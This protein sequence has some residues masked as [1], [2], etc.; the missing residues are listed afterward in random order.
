MKVGIAGYSGSGVTT[1]MALLAEVPAL[2][3][4]RGGGPEVRSVKIPDARLDGL[5]RIFHP[6]KTTPVQMEM[7]EIGDLR[8]EEGG[9]LRK[10]ALGRTRGLDA[11]VLVLKGFAT[12]LD[13]PCRPEAEVAAELSDIFGEFCLSDLLPVENRLQRLKKEGKLSSGEA[14]L[15]ERVRMSLEEGKPLRV[16]GL[17][18]EEKRVLQGY[19]FLTLFPTLTVANVGEAGAGNQ[20]F[21]GLAG[22]CRGEGIG[23]LEVAGKTEL[24]LLDL[25]EEER[26]PFLADLGIPSSS[27]ERLVKGVFDLLGLITFFTVGEDEVRGWEI[28]AGLKAQRAAGRIHSDLERGFIRAEVVRYEDFLAAGSMAKARETGKLRIEGKEYAVQDGDIFHVRFN[29]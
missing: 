1:V 21:P 8:P 19:Q 25:P 26:E 15:L 12:P 18:P 2:A 9:G 3:S 5:S 17:D 13:S 6:R 16:A 29:V 28:P 14:H 11:L 4:H 22:R 27:R 20:A 10:E 23:Y 7:V 24:E